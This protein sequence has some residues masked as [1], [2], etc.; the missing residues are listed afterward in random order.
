LH[1]DLKASTHDDLTLLNQIMKE[2]RSDRK[3]RQKD[4]T[5]RSD[6]KIMSESKINKVEKI[7]QTDNT[8]SYQQLIYCD[9]QRE[10]KSQKLLFFKRYIIIRKM[11]IY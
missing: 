3:I 2:S 1:D 4:Q 11:Q 7:M 6:R 5:E 9:R 10:N 8:S